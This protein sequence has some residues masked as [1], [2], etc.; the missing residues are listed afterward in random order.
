M[1]RDAEEAALAVVGS[2]R[3]A[4]VEEGLRE[5]LA[6]RASEGSSQPSLAR[7]ASEFDRIVSFLRRCDEARFSPNRENPLSLTTEG[8]AL[9][10]RL[11]AME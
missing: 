11:E 5:L 8:E 1:K 10:A 7:P 4:E 9:L 3:G 2:K 6:R